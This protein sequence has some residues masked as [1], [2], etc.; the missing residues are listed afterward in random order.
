MP[1][2]YAVRDFVSVAK[3]LS[4]PTRLR[5]LLAL[6]TGELCV[7]QLVELL[8]A[9]SSTV[10][11]HMALLDRAYLVNV[12]REGR[13]AF[14]RRAGHDAPEAVSAA[15]DWIDRSI[16]SSPT[17]EQ[18]GERLKQITRIPPEELCRTRDTA[19]RSADPGTADSSASS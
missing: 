19:S 7:C 3:A 11:R 14:Y 17:A 4:D 2:S 9:A 15:L 1:G 12:R 13:W 6:G 18:D 5:I 8:G 10:S 16:G